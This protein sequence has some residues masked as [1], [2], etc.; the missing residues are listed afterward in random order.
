M[1]GKVDLRVGN[2]ARV[3]ALAIGTYCLTLPSGLVL[4]LLNCYYVSAMSKNILSVSCLDNA[5]F[6]FI[7]KNNNLSIYH[8]DIFYGVAILSFGLY[9]LNLE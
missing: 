7:I 5:S 4:Q 9:V 8:G 6:H 2:G 3:A 1:K